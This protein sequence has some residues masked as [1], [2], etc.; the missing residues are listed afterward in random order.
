MRSVIVVLLAL[1][2]VAC[3]RSDSDLVTGYVEADFVYLAPATAGVL[4]ELKVK[5]GDQVA[6]G[7][8]LFELETDAEQLALRAASERAQ[9]AGA[10][11]ADL[12][13]GKRADELRAIEEQ[14]AQAAAAQ[15]LS[16]ALL[17]RTESLVAQ[18]FESEVRLIEMRSTAARDDARVRELQ[19]QLKVARAAARPDEIAAAESERRA[20][21]AEAAQAAWRQEQRGRVAPQDA[22]VFDVMYRPGEWVPAGAPVVALLPDGALKLRAYV[23]QARLAQLQLGQ[24]VGVRCDGCPADLTARV[25][26]IS[27]QAEY[28]P[29]VIYSNESRSKLVFLVEARPDAVAAEVLKPGQPVNVILP[30]VRR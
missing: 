27:P 13:K 5:R 2:A 7:R 10:Q 29:P 28:T 8:P 15:Q 1:L 4:Q 23:P 26:F 30:A 11:L 25:S 21:Q 24:E 22:V 9:R 20:M 16:A 18:G 12:S 14:L 17:R 19:A 3:T 6:A